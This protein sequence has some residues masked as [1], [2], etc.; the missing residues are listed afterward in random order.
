MVI[1]TYG[2]KPLR[3]DLSPKQTQKSILIRKFTNINLEAKQKQK[4]KKSAIFKNRTKI[5]SS[6]KLININFV[7][8]NV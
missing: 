8:R 1:I 6:Q 4:R 2:E 5:Y 7:Q 3:F